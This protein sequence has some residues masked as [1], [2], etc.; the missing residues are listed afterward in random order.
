MNQKGQ[1]LLEALFV[2]PA[3][4]LLFTA[5]AAIL[6]NSIQ[7]TYLNDIAEE[8]LICSRE[9]KYDCKQ[10]ATFKIDQV[11]YKIIDM[12]IYNESDQKRLVLQFFNLFNQK[13]KLERFITVE[14]K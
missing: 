10:T 4:V 9:N 1:S 3:T 6:M 11:G 12:Q 14:K 13:Q 7:L 8:I 5:M 2:L